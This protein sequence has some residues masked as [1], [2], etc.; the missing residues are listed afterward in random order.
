[1]IESLAIVAG[2]GEYPLVMAKGAR[3]AG[4][5]HLSALAIRGAADKRRLRPLVDE[6]VPVGLGELEKVRDW[7]AAHP[8]VAL[9][10]G[11]G[12]SPTSLFSTRFDALSRK[13]LSELS[14]KNARTIFGKVC[15]VLGQTGVR[16]LPASC[17]MDSAIPSAGCL[18]KRQ[19]DARE[20]N[21]IAIG[22]RTSLL[23]AAAEIGQVVVVKEGVICAVEAFEGTNA[24]IKR[25]AT[26]GG[27][28]SVVFKGAMGGHDIRFD[29][30]AF[31]M[32]TLAF[33]RKMRVSVFAFQ[34]DR[35]ILLDRE[36]VLEHADKWGISI[37]AVDSG[38]ESFRQQP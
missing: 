18:T 17:F 9:E 25:G 28:G 15:E 8:H 11:G 16:I 32:K 4:V 24:T 35:M 14:V 38:L 6:W 2:G 30:P 36:Q 26:I 5:R 7:C 12:I 13:L 19:P 34:A 10:F 1:M 3:A 31:G 23:I 21:D 20:Q 37:V 29:I 22:S 33:L 27:K